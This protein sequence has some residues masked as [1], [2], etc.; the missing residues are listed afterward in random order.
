MKEQLIWGL[1][2]SQLSHRDCWKEG[3]S[4][5]RDQ[6]ERTGSIPDLKCSLGPA[7]TGSCP[8]KWVAKFGGGPVASCHACCFVSFRKSIAFRSNELL[9]KL[10]AAG[11]GDRPVIWVSHSMGG[12]CVSFWVAGGEGV[13]SPRG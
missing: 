11:V 2:Y 12:E 7:H 13:V 1:R 5:C 6:A 4:N 8:K 10:R 9:R 3:T